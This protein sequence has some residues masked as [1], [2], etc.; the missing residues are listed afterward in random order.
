MRRLGPPL[1]A[2]SLLLGA[3][4][5]AQARLVD[6]HAGLRAG[7]FTGRSLSGGRDAASRDFF[8]AVRG[9]A[10]GI[11]VGCT[12][13]GLDLSLRFYQVLGGE[14]ELGDPGRRLPKRG[15][16]IGDP[17]YELPGP[18]GGLATG[19]LTQLLLG[20]QMEFPIPASLVLRPRIAGG[21]ALG[22]TGPIELP[23]GNDEVTHKGV[24]AEAEVA[25]LRYVNRF[26]SIGASIG[27]GGH[28]L[29]GGN[30]VVNDSRNWGKGLHVIGLMTATAH[31]G[32]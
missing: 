25:L 8:E 20:F 11:D 4:G 2:T 30:L 29:L 15:G 3:S 26:F 19:T 24:V 1:L 13:V 32:F 18:Q 6:L 9:P 27:L 16:E 17:G 31:L 14:G 22:T 21:F 28:Y 23:L 5:A 7:G 10:A 12:L